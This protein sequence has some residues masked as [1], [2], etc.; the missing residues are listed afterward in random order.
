MKIFLTLLFLLFL[1]TVIIFMLYQKNK[2]N[3]EPKAVPDFNTDLPL[4]LVIKLYPTNNFIKD[5]AWIKS[6]PNY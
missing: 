2:S 3:S 6:T 5:K 1:E 4:T